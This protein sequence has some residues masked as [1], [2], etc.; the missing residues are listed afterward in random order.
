MVDPDMHEEGCTDLVPLFSDFTEIHDIIGEKKQQ[1]R[2]GV[3]IGRRNKDK[4]PTWLIATSLANSLIT[5]I[6]QLLDARGAF[7]K[8]SAP[9]AK[10]ARLIV[11]G[12]RLEW[13]Q[14]FKE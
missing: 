7:F 12:R 11:Q 6:L 10:V 14:C 8:H 2:L 4:Y 9:A 1:S 5:P 3:F 13:N